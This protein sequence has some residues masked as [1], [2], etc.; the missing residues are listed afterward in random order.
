MA[1]EI[2]RLENPAKLLLDSGLLFEINRILLHPLGMALEINV[3][4]ETG[5]PVSIGGIWD[6]RDDPE[7]ILYGEDELEIGF[8]KI[9]K[10]MEEFGNEKIQQRYETVG[11]ITQGVS[12][13]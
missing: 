10:F 1:E 12:E 7:G 9:T 8:E 3:D 2:K 13:E 5:D 4:D 11:F 6:Y